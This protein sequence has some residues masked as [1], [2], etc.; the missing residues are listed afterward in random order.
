[1]DN[2]VQAVLAVSVLNSARVQK[3]T[4]KNYMSKGKKNTG[5]KCGTA[6]WDSNNKGTFLFVNNLKN[7]TI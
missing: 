5:R 4:K 2:G 7:T 1:M 3:G 6:K